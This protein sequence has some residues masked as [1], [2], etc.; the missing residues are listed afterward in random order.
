MCKISGLRLPET[1]F[2]VDPPYYRT[3]GKLPGGL[4]RADHEALA[5]LLRGIKG[6]FVL[7][8]NDSKETCAIYRDTGGRIE[9]AQ[10]TRTAAGGSGAK[11]AAGIIVRRL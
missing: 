10:L 3:E 7:T 9:R 4:P 1:L 8:M 6:R 5:A 2:Y 11:R